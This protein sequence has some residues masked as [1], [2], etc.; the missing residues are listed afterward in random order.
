MPSKGVYCHVKQLWKAVLSK[1]YKDATFKNLDKEKF[2]PLLKLVYES[3]KFFRGLHAIAGFQY[4]GLF[5][6]N[7]NS[8][9]QQAIATPALR[10]D[11]FKALQESIK[12][13]M[14]N[15][16][17]IFFQ[18]KGQSHVKKSR[19]S[20]IQKVAEVSQYS[21]LLIFSKKRRSKKTKAKQLKLAEKQ[22]KKCKTNNK[23]SMP[24]QNPAE[25][26]EAEDEEQII[27][28]AA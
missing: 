24:P 4:T 17:K 26:K 6:L 10:F 23:L 21:I 15:E 22:T 20:N 3:G 9:N 28:P 7:K 25:K 8:I 13:E 2:L 14:E 16:V 11:K 27:P 18:E 19:Q 5:P 1:Y 12:K